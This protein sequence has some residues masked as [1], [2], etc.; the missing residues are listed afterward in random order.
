MRLIVLALL[1]L[2][3]VTVKSEWVIVACHGGHT[4]YS[5]GERT[6]WLLKKD[7]LACGFQV[8]IPT[9]HYEQIPVKQ[10]GVIP[11][12]IGLVGFDNYFNDYCNDL[13]IFGI[14]KSL[15]VLPGVEIANEDPPYHTL[16]FGE[17]IRDFC[18]TPNSE[19]VIEQLETLKKYGL[20][21]VLAHPHW[22]IDNLPIDKLHNYC[23]IEFFNNYN[24]DDFY[25]DLSLYMELINLGQLVF[26]TSGIDVH[27]IEDPMEL[28]RFARQTLVWAE[29][30]SENTI[31]SGFRKGSVIAANHNIVVKNC[32]PLPGFTTL[33]SALPRIYLDISFK[34]VQLIER[35]LKIY[36]D[37]TLVYETTI[38]VG[39]TDLCVDF[40]DTQAIPGLHRYIAVIDQ[41]LVTAPWIFEVLENDF[42][43]GII[44]K[45]AILCPRDN[46]WE[47]NGRHIL[48]VERDLNQQSTLNYNLGDFVTA[49]VIYE[50]PIEYPDNIRT[51]ITG[52]FIELVDSRGVRYLRGGASI[53]TQDRWRMSQQDFRFKLLD[54]GRFTVK[55]TDID[56]KKTYC[57]FQ[58]EVK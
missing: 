19:T 45:N 32:K 52:F 20:V 51:G 29:T 12:I 53:N 2:Q 8:L 16:A 44:I 10:K 23:G 3:V 22:K 24:P 5:D 4:R 57:E 36:R 54:R 46:S 21:T 13:D 40:I 33:K 25:K 31:L 58:I 41:C 55:L 26:P 7:A 30:I 15:L 42:P 35:K 47:G 1:V 18:D 43:K 27:Y 14:K 49:S 17:K 48:R 28:L 6:P 38:D 39:K 11:D 37:R 9:D 56:R 50:R 34:T